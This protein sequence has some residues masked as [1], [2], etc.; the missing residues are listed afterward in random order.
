MR[1]LI[2]GTTSGLGRH[3]HETLGGTGW[4][5]DLPDQERQRL[6]REGV[7]VIVHCAWKPPPRITADHL[8]PYLGDTLLLTQELLAIPHRKFIFLSTNEV[9]PP[10]PG[11]RREDEPIE[12]DAVRGIY[13]ITKI[14]AESLVRQ[15]SP[16]HLILRSAG[17]LGP[18][19]RKNVVRRILEDDPCQL[20]LA[21][22]SRFNYMLHAD[23]GQFL[24][25][26]IDSDLAGLYNMASAEGVSL[27]EVAAMFGR[28]V[29]FGTYRYPMS[30]LDNTR[31]GVLF[32]P[33]QKTSRTVIREFAAQMGISG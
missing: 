20:T 9:Y 6:R 13:G 11:L 18:Y 12:V 22:E 1:L 21:P 3:L 10:G 24:R 32:P 31:I 5:R 4:S 16:N 14:M 27:D 26:A 23:V 19:A 17:L 30:E 15:C 33:F 7:D 29:Q 8:Y 25:T 28:R 2:S